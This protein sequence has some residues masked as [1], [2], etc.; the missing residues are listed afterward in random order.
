LELL[1]RKIVT[2][3][4]FVAPEREIPNWRESAK[5]L[6]ESFGSA[7]NVG[8]IRDLQE[9]CVTTRPV[10][11]EPLLEAPRALKIR[12]ALNLRA[13]IVAVLNGVLWN[14]GPEFYSLLCDEF[15]SHD[16]I[17]APSVAGE[18]ALRKLFCM[19]VRDISQP[20]RIVRIPRGV[21]LHRMKPVPRLEARK[22]LGIP[23]E[24]MVVTSVGRLHDLS[25]A[26]M[27]PLLWAVAEIARDIDCH[28]VCAGTDPNGYAKEISSIAKHYGIADRL[29]IIRDFALIDKPLIYGTADIFVSLADN[30][31]ETFGVVILEAM[32]A[33]LPVIASNWS[34]Y[35]DLVDDGTTG[36]LID[37]FWNAAVA[38]E[39]DLDSLVEPWEPPAATLARGTIVSREHL[40]RSLL[41]L[42]RDEHL[43]NSFGKA[44]VARV[45]TH[46][47]AGAIADAYASLISDL[48]RGASTYRNAQIRF[49]ISSVFQGY[50]NKVLRSDTV[51]TI[52]EQRYDSHLVSSNVGLES[53]P[54]AD[55]LYRRVVQERRVETDLLTGRS[56][57]AAGWLL[58][59]GFVA[60]TTKEAETVVESY[61]CSKIVRT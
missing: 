39:A 29:T 47:E 56:A 19:A 33:G 30:I 16:A 25:K 58:K 42:G 48:E 54:E 15:T 20:P 11:V 23:S 41:T 6:V 52:P 53:N 55:I 22:R 18:D 4:F 21:N 17:S 44:G 35:R 43:R 38:H 51:L 45:R 27:E 34:G 8:G 10:F 1:D 5:E 46:F 49:N 9:A 7:I 40:K 36:F 37:T 57:L 24:R 12:S 59:R 61:D 50:A 3:V 28:L 31:W 26:D 13:P 2:S 32:A 14:V 60:P